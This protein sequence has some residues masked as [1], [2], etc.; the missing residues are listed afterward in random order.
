[1]VS[2][3]PVA[4]WKNIFVDVKDVDW[5]YDAV[6]Y[7]NYHKLFAGYGDGVFAPTDSMT[8]AM[9]ATVLWNMEGN[10][11]PDAKTSAFADVADDMW[12]A[13]A[14][15]WSVDNGI[16]VQTDD[17][18]YPN[19]GITR[20][21]MA[22]T[23]YNYILFKKYDIPRHRDML[24]YR[25]MNNVAPWAVEAVIKL[26]E[27]GVMSG[28]DVNVFAPNDTATRAHVAQIFKNLLWFVTER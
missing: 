8:R 23:I 20:Q 11:A 13:A 22:A 2:Y 14:V 5:F 17:N 19:R 4:L 24:N 10:P 7:A 9:F 27:A 1:V 3:D 15:Q 28:V 12:F 18:Y 26:S 6:A 16:A 25:D 21:E